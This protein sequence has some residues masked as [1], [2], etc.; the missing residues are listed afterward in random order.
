M[1]YFNSHPWGL[2][3]LFLQ[4]GEPNNSIQILSAQFAVGIKLNSLLYKQKEND[5]CLDK[6]ILTKGFHTEKED[7]KNSSRNSTEHLNPSHLVEEKNPLTLYCVPRFLFWQGMIRVARCVY[8][9]SAGV[10]IYIPANYINT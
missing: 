3:I 2:L 8:G 10:Y 7:G 6:H 9:Y 1:L 5:K 4:P